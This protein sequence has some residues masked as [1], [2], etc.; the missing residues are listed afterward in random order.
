M[1]PGN[2]WDRLI[3]FFKPGIVPVGDDTITEDDPLGA[4]WL[5]AMLIGMLALGLASN[6]AIHDFFDGHYWI[7]S[8]NVFAAAAAAFSVFWAIKYGSVVA[9][10]FL[11]VLPLLFSLCWRTLAQGA[12]GLPAAGWWL[13]VLPFVLSAGGFHVTAGVFLAAFVACTSIIYTAPS[14]N[15]VASHYPSSVEPAGQFLAAVG[16]ELMA[17]MVIVFSMCRHASIHRS[18]AAAKR[19]A[20]DAAAVKSRFLANMSHEIRTPLLGLIGAIELMRSK[21]TSTTQRQQLITLAETS[22]QTLHTL[23]NDVLDYS[24]LDSGELTLETGPVS[25]QDVCFQINELF[26]VKAFDKGLE[27]TTSIDADVPALFQADGTR[28]KQLLSNLVSNAIKFT[29]RGGVHIHLGIDHEHPAG[30]GQSEDGPAPMVV[31]ITVSDTGIGIDPQSAA[32]LFKPFAQ[33]DSSITRRFGGTG[34][35]LSI[36]AEL[37]QAMGG[38]VGLTS[39]PGKGSTFVFRAPLIPCAP[40]SPAVAASGGATVLVATASTGLEV[41]VCS[42]LEQLGRGYRHCRG[43]PT[44]EQY[45]GHNCLVLDSTLLTGLDPAKIVSRYS[46]AGL[47]VVLLHPLGSDNVVGLFGASSNVSMLHKPVRKRALRKALE[48][49]SRLNQAVR[50]V[51]DVFADSTQPLRQ[52]SFK[53]VSILV[54]EDNPVNQVVIEAMIADTGANCTI[55]SNGAEAVEAF[56]KAR[57]DIVLMDLQMPVMDGFDATRAIREAEA[58]QPPVPIIAMTAN[59]ERDEA[60]ARQDAGMS[61]YLGKPFR[62]ADITNV[63]S[64]WCAP[65]EV[66]QAR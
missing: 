21:S 65:A 58:G 19:A 26:A 33:A 64:T 3:D 27:L 14:W 24:K 39:V 9:P 5:Y 10:T 44:P 63:L 56:A 6:Y 55:V 42:L 2:A 16:S 50:E 13:S 43:L 36:C 48:P 30:I 61:G 40:P 29:A 49:L 53:D 47:H 18:M 17:V 4:R 8:A 35:G 32:C 54:A 20:V 7:G 23:I 11:A 51:A 38:E 46:A 52:T 66:D 25:L 12:D 22:A 59:S 1:A 57:F 62:L 34:L 41:H 45:I 31:S 15:F 37:A 28:I 60:A